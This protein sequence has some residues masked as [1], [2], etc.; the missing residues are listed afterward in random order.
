MC[1]KTAPSIMPVS[2]LVASRM[3][4]RLAASR[5]LI[6]RSPVEARFTLPAHEALVGCL[7]RA[8]GVVLSRWHL[9]DDEQDSA[10]LIVGELAA[11]AAVHGRSEMSLHMVLAEGTLGI[12]VGDHGEPAPTPRRPTGGD[13]DERGRGLDIVH[14]LSTRVD[15][16]HG[17]HDTWILA[18][19]AVTP[20]GPGAD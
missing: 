10:L 1:S 17:D 8:A 3:H 2:A 14:A 5:A 20:G 7:R 16:H 11:N 15:L 19:L 12:V 13:P 18:H 6:P 9:S 4:T